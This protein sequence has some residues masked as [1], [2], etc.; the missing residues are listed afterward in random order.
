[1]PL[2]MTS[3]NVS[4]E[5]IVIDNNDALLRLRGVADLFVLHD[6]DIVTR[7]DDSVARVIAGR[8]VVLRRAR[9]YVPRAI[10]SPVTFDAAVLACGA[11][12]KNTFCYGRG[13]E[14]VLGPHIGDLDS[15]RVFRD[16][17]AAIARMGQFL[18]V[19]PE[20]VAHD[21]HPDYLSTRYAL[22]TIGAVAVGVQHHH[23]HVA[24]AMAEHGLRGPVLGLAYDGTGYGTDGAAWGGELLVADYT[25]FTRLAT[26]RPLALAGGDMAIRQPWRVALAMIDDAFNGEAPIDA[27]SLFRRI[28]PTDLDVVLRMIHRRFNA[29]LAHG[30][31]RYFDAFGALVLGRPYASYEGQIAFEL[32]AAADPAER[33][34]YDYAID[35]APSPWQ[36]DMRAAVRAAVF[37][38]LGGEAPSLIAARIHNTLAAAS[39]DLIR[40]AA[41]G[42]GRLP[43]VLSGGCFQ[44]ARLAESIQRGLQP[45]FAVH[46]HERVPP[47][48]GGIA[49]GQAC[50]AA[51]RARRL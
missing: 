15:T 26:F 34:R 43:V 11:Q 16:Y 30:V 45:E 13:R 32:D 31:G 28:A 20:I 7:A 24:S 39:I 3:G 51:A 12:L 37:E 29:P 23:A 41:R 1:V 5:P 38:L 10:A 35:Q 27:V 17:E 14:A 2:V 48:D 49:L 22:G 33:R 9:G 25:E 6:R 8:P 42:A 46:L 19:T 40:A 18:D 44:N 50:V 47:G 21:L 4:E 36:V